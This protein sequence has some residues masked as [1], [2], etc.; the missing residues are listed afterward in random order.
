MK[1]LVE[2]PLDQGGSVLIEVEEP[3]AGPVTRGL[4]KDRAVL[5]QKAD[6]TFEDATAAV[7]PAAQ[8]LLARLSSIKEPPDE[9]G[10]LFGVQLS[11]QAGAFIAS[12]AAQANFTVSMTWRR[13][14]G[15]DR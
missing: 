11:A 4:G 9:I 8:S 6:K 2:Y 5:V 1:R 3:P 10:I 13:S 12:V 7:V 14:Q 15:S